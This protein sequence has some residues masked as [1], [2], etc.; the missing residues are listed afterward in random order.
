M[1]LNAKSALHI[2][3]RCNFF[4][5][6]LLLLLDSFASLKAYE[7][8]NCNVGTVL[9]CNLFNIFCNCKVAVLNVYLIEQA[10]LFHLFVETS[11]DHLLDDVR[12]S[13]ASPGSLS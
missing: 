4:S 5:K 9:F 11:D 1:K 8:L 10:D 2:H 6:V 13:P 3:L 12:C 7:L